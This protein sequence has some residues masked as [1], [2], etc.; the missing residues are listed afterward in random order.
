MILSFLTVMML[1][2]LVQSIHALLIKIL[3]FGLYAYINYDKFNLN[4]DYVEDFNSKRSQYVNLNF[5]FS[6]L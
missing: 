4:L 5:S 3:I 1:T 6:K 2:D